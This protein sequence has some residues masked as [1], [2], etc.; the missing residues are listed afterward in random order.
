ML[1]STRAG[2]NARPLRFPAGSWIGFS[3]QFVGFAADAVLLL[4]LLP[5]H[6]YPPC[7]KPSALD[8][9][10]VWAAKPSVADFYLQIVAVLKPNLLRLHVRPQHC[11]VAVQGLPLG[12]HLRQA[13]PPAMSLEQYEPWQQREV[14]EQRWCSPRQ[15][16]ARAQAA[17][18][19]ARSTL[20]SG[21]A[22]TTLASSRWHWAPNKP[23]VLA[24]AGSQAGAGGPGIPWFSASSIVASERQWPRSNLPDVTASSTRQ[25]E[26]I[27]NFWRSGTHLGSLKNSSRLEELDA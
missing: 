21:S 3:F 1:T 22:A 18:N 10:R 16:P 23:K 2:R 6:I 12:T 17:R 8:L 7:C 4:L 19:R 11:A 5:P 14:A 15:E 24:H 20:G 27:R 25:L 13:A 9:G 26:V